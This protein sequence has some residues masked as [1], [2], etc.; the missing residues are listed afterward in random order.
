[1]AF[2]VIIIMVLFIEKKNWMNEKKIQIMLLNGTIKKMKKKMKVH[3]HWKSIMVL[4][5]TF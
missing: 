1:M 5:S 4:L 2:M 3:C